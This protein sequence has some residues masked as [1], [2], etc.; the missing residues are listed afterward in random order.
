MINKGYSGEDQFLWFTGV[1]ESRNDPLAL[2][3]VQVRIRGVHNASLTELPSADLPWAHVIRP[4]TDKGFSAPKESE[5]VIGFFMDGYNKQL[6]VIFGVLEGFETNKPDTGTGFHDLRPPSTIALAPKKPTKRTFAKDGSGIVVEEANVGDP[7]IVESLRHPNAD[8]L[9]HQSISGITR[10]QQLANTVIAARKSN[11]DKDVVTA[12]GVQWSEP[13]PA[14]NPLYPYNNATETESGHIFELDDTPTAERVALTHRTGTGFEVFPTGTKV[15]KIT[16]SN[17]QIIMADD[18]LHV[19]GK[20]MITVDADALIKVLGDVIIEGGNNL[21]LKVA[22]TMNVAVG[23]ALNIKAKSLNMDITGDTTLVTGGGQ[24]IKAGG[25]INQKAGGNI[26]DQAA[27][28]INEKA[29]GSFK[30]T[31]SSID[32]TGTI[33]ITGEMDTLLVTVITD[34]GGD[35]IVVGTPVNIQNS[36]AAAAGPAT[37]GS[38]AGIKA[39]GSRATKNKGEASLEQVPVP[40]S[41]TLVDF[42][43]ETGTAFKQRQFLTQAANTKYVESPPSNTTPSPCNFDPTTKTFIDDPSQWNIGDAGLSLIKESEQFA[44]VVSPNQVTAYP[45]PATK[46]EPLTI[47]YGSTAVGIDAPV[48]LGELISRE[49][50]ENNLTYTVNKKVIPVLRQTVSVGLTQN[51][52]DALCDLIYNIGENNWRMSTL[53]KR[54]NDKKWCEA[55]DQFLVWNKAGGQVL[56]GLTTRRKKDKDLFLS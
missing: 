9:D 31:G 8:E 34:T 38:A 44:K 48:T 26:N 5:L 1:V 51:M 7:K 24:F 20:V 22:G 41:N 6:P 42:D 56:G 19:M 13:Y 50:A 4:G 36:T 11:L 52:I 27:G 47:G 32:L 39:A 25:D 45:D 12:N 28:D 43:P 55:G 33:N 17:Y 14:F 29:G 35:S 21:D 16:K 2:G 10:Y 15:E 3:R 46:G 54:V 18:H 30:A 40:L 53:R 49:T 37:D 23:E